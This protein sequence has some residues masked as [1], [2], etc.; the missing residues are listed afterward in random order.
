QS[1]SQLQVGNPM[2]SSWS[3]LRGTA[4]WPENAGWAGQYAAHT[5]VYAAFERSFPPPLFIELQQRLHVSFRYRAPISPCGQ[6]SEDFACARWLLAVLERQAAQHL[7]STGGFTGAGS[8]EGPPDR[9]H[10]E[11]WPTD[12]FECVHG[13]T[14][15]PLQAPCANGALL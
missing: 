13:T 10:F 7:A 1:R 9:Y 14:Q 4:F 8:I 11:M 3:Q 12:G 6:R 15:E 2:G 5:H